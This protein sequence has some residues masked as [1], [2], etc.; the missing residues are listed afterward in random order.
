M[1]IVGDGISQYYDRAVNSLAWDGEDQEYVGT[2][3]DSYDL[4]HDELARIS[5]NEDVLQAIIDALG[6]EV[7]CDQEPYATTGF[8][9]YQSSWEQF[10]N[11]VKH[12]TRYFFGTRHR[13]DGDDFN[14]TP[15]S[16]MLREISQLLEEENL[17][18]TIDTMTVF[19]RVRVHS[20]L[21][22][23]GDWR[24]LG[25]PP[26]SRAPSNRMSAAPRRPYSSDR[27]IYSPRSTYS[28]CQPKINN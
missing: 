14:I 3:Y 8:E 19:T 6:D 18:R 28:G 9:A 13:R 10:C 17:I 24:S 7:W 2:T 23:C 11:A 12:E 4:V 1:E 25:P 16:D 21:E 22:Q 5:D 15:V 27:T 26:P 20:P